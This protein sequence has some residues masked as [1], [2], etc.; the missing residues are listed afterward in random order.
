LT[1]YTEHRLDSDTANHLG[2]LIA[3]YAMEN[4]V[5]DIV[6]FCSLASILGDI[7]GT[8]IS[9]GCCEAELFTANFHANYDRAVAQYESTNERKH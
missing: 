7:A 8:H 5:P 2:D 3:A 1:E 4:D 6:L 9:A